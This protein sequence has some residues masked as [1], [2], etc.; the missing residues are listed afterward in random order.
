MTGFLIL[1]EV[2]GGVSKT[3][4]MDFWR[5]DF[6]LFRT[7]VERVPWERVLTGKGVQKGWTFFKEV[8]LKAQ[9]QVVP[10]YCKTNWWRRQLAWLNRE[11]LLG[12]RKN[13]KFYYLWKKGQAM[14]EEYRGLIRLCSEEIKQAKA[15]LELRLAIVARENKKCFNKYI[16]NKKGPRRIQ[17]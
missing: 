9:E 16:N 3:T 5:A 6:G 11:I 2:K 8:V 7:L 10:V 12:L 13:K 14:Q 15:Q 1:G 17:G 4:T